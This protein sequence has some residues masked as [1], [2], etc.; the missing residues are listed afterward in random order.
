M[1]LPPW[2]WI[3]IAPAA[4]AKFK[5]PAEHYYSLGTA[6]TVPAELGPALRTYLCEHHG[7]LALLAPQGLATDPSQVLAPEVKAGI[8][9]HDLRAPAP[10]HAP[11]PQWMPGPR[12]QAWLWQGSPKA[13]LR[14]TGPTWRAGVGTPQGGEAIILLSCVRRLAQQ[15]GLFWLV[16]DWEAAVGALRTYQEGFHCGD[17]IHHLYAIS[18]GVRRLSPTSAINVVTMPSPWI[19][20]LNVHVDA[21]T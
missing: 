20:D 4:V 9:F 19:T 16:P 8:W 15:P 1:T 12:K 6:G 10:P 13:G 2:P 3:A 17:G 18:L 5:Y 14:P 11:W 7:D 21:A